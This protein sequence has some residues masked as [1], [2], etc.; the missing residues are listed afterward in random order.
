M[1]NTK[2]GEEL[3]LAMAHEPSP[4]L[5]REFDAFFY[6]RVLRY[7][8]LRHRDFGRVAPHVPV[9]AMDMTPE[10]LEEIA[11]VT[12]IT[13]CARARAS[14][15]EFD[16]A[17]GSAEWWVLR[18]AAYAFWEVAAALEGTRRRLRV[19]PTEDSDLHQR[20]DD[21][22]GASDTFDIVA[23]RERLFSMF[24]LLNVEEQQAV[25][26]CHRDGH[27]YAQAAEILYGDAAKSKTVDRLLQSAMI[28]MRDDPSMRSR[29][30]S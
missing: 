8:Q 5:V 9:I 29:E 22:G 30:T 16:P 11:H 3:M 13:A 19:V 15:A 27:T 12:A 2:R 4:Q 26:L 10:K 6:P 21:A 18:N 17:R 28:K 24:K 25:I 14:A 23:A 1:R 20:V 7:A